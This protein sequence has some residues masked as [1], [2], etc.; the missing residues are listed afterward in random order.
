MAKSVAMDGPI[1]ARGYARLR[2]GPLQRTLQNR[3]P[4]DPAGSRTVRQL[5]R[6]KHKLPLER[7]RRPR[8][9]PL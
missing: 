9:L 8:I 5:P 1:Q 4:P 7:L 3:M 6:C 2:H